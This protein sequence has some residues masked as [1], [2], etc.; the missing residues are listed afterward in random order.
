MEG[1]VGATEELSSIIKIGAVTFDEKCIIG[2]SLATVFKG[3]L[4]NEKIV[5][6]KRIEVKNQCIETSEDRLMELKGSPNIVQLFHVEK[7]RNF[8]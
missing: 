2:R 6:V 7:D 5:A 4:N 8:R 3:T 1:E